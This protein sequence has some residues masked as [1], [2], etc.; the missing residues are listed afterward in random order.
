MKIHSSIGMSACDLLR[1]VCLYGQGGANGT[2][3]G[4]GD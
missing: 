1:L 2:I 3:L 4:N